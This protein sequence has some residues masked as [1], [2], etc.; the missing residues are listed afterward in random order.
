MMEKHDKTR[1][2]AFG[3]RNGNRAGATAK[4]AASRVGMASPGE[5]T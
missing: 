1:V 3:G 2:P 4:V 5:I